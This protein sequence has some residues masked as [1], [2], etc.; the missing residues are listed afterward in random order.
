MEK[1]D[2]TIT[3]MYLLI[4]LGCSGRAFDSRTG[5]QETLDALRT[6]VAQ[7]L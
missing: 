5:I 1:K 6:K 3:Y 7:H 4:F 2:D